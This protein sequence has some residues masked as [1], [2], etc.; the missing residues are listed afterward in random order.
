MTCKACL[1]ARAGS[2]RKL[3]HYD[4]PLV[5]FDVFFLTGPS[6]HSSSHSSSSPSEG[7]AGRRSEEAGKGWTT[8]VFPLRY[9]MWQRRELV[10]LMEQAGLANVHKVECDWELRLAATRPA[11]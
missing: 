8:E 6:S 5:T 4:D 11:Q 2:A 9:R 10:E 3:W 7:E 1:T